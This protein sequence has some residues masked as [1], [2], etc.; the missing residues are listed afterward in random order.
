MPTMLKKLLG[1]KY[2][3]PESCPSARYTVLNRHELFENV[4]LFVSPIA[5]RKA[6]LVCKA[7]RSV[8][9]RSPSLQQAKVEN[10]DFK[11]LLLGD[12]SVE[13]T[14]LTSAVRRLTFCSS[15]QP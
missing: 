13:K 7:W 3:S 12:C 4:L 8:T 6:G 9:E 1:M 10:G 11:L 15:S 5:L 14:V 2:K